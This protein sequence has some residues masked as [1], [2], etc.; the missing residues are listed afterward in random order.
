M[1]Q[2]RC[3][4]AIELPDEVKT[5]L[6]QLEAQLK[7]G[8]QPWVKWV[9]P[10]SIHL[11]LKF[12]G[13][14]AADRI[15]KITRAMGEAVQ[16]AS[17]FHLEVKDLGV[18]PNLRRVQVAWVGVSGEVDKL[19]QLQQRIESSLVPQGFTAE[20]RPFTPHLTL[21]RIRDRASP[22]ERQRFGQLIADTKFEAAYTFQVDAISLMRSQLTRE[23]A[24]YSRIGSVELNRDCLSTSPPVCN[25]RHR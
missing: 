8:N 2:I 6:T 19:V 23:G 13:N 17:P 7:S 14:V 24:I 20:S 11:T 22:D 18:F 10:Y 1:E 5:G 9:D 4:I 3:F 12:L 25:R 21:A 16:G 15:D